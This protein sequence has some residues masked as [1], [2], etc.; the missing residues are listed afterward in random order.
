MPCASAVKRYR[1]KNP[2]EEHRWIEALGPRRV[3]LERLPSRQEQYLKAVRAGTHWR[4]L[5]RVVDWH[6]INRVRASDP[7][8]ATRLAEARQAGKATV[9]RQASARKLSP[10][11]VYNLVENATR[12]VRPEMRDDVRGDLMLALLEGSVSA[13]GAASA[14]R[15]LI[16][17]WRRNFDR[18]DLSFDQEL[19]EGEGFSLHG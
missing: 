16:T 4:D 5:G 12:H 18:R 13:D 11:E 15:G 9:A 3:R 7:I 1:T 6:A 17:A 2:A 10:S 8:F 14:V 19:G